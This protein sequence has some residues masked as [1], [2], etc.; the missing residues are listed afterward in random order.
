MI[1]YYNIQNDIGGKDQLRTHMQGFCSYG[2]RKRRSP[3]HEVGVK[4]NQKRSQA[5]GFEIAADDS[6][7]FLNP[8]D[9]AGD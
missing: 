2:P 3:G 8:K 5:S 9:L 7:Q 1:K 4:A 6:R